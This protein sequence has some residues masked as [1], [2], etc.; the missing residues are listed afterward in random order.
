MCYSTP[1]EVD[2][3]KGFCHHNV[4][5][6]CPLLPASLP[7]TS[8]CQGMPLHKSI[9]TEKERPFACW[10]CFTRLPS[11]RH[12]Q[13]L[14][15]APLKYEAAW[16]RQK[17]SSPPGPASFLRKA[18]NCADSLFGEGAVGNSTQSG[19]EPKHGYIKDIYFDYLLA[20]FGKNFPRSL[21]FKFCLQN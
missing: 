13:G 14:C 7:V 1:E 9:Q 6:P 18:L 11:Q 2:L 8:M 21:L 16:K 5:C 19:S 20:I 17:P 10:L 12:L 3:S 15:R 4:S